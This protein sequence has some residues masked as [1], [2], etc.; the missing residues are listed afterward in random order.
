MP[1]SWQRRASGLA[2]SDRIVSFQG[3]FAPLPRTNA[4]RA[5]SGDPR[6]SVERLY[7]TREAFLARADAA[8]RELVAA[9]FLLDEDVAAARARMAAT[10]DWTMEH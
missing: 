1:W 7:G 3:T 2:A 4:E 6:P 5:A 10:W 9:R 8:A